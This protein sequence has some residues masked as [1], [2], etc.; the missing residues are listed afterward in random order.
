MVEGTEKANLGQCLGL[1]YGKKKKNI[2]NVMV[3]T[4]CLI[5]VTVS[6]GWDGEVVI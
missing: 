3:L 5:I 2:E 6:G 1:P 4:C